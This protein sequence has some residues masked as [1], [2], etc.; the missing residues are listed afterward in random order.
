MTAHTFMRVLASWNSPALAWA[1]MGLAHQH[2][3]ENPLLPVRLELRPPGY[4]SNRSPEIHLMKNLKNI[5]HVFKTY[6][7]KKFLV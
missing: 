4:K 2:I 5:L 1:L 3:T 6:M 7:K